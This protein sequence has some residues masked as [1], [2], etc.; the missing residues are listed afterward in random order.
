MQIGLG[1]NNPKPVQVQR[2]HMLLQF[3]GE[4]TVAEA[5]LQEATMGTWLNNSDHPR[6]IDLA[7]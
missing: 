1:F 2:Y 7:H 6:F 3:T 4:N 5:M